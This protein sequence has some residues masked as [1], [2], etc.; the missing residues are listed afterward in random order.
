[1]TVCDMAMPIADDWYLKRDMGEGITLIIEPHVDVLM[2]ANIWHVR[3]RDRDLLVDS[4]M[5]IVPLRPYFPELF[6]GRETIALATHTHVDHI[7]AIHEFEHRWVHPVEAEALQ[8][9]GGGTLVC[10]EINPDAR[11]RFIAAG[12]PPLG[13]YLVHALPHAG[14]DPK[15]Y[16]LRGARPTRLIREGETVDLGDRQYT[17]LLVPGHSPGSIALFEE[18]TGTLFAGDVIYDGPLLYQGP[19]MDIGDYVRSFERL[20]S[21]PITTVHAGHDPSFSKTRL[22]AIIDAYM[23]RWRSEGLIGP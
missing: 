12:Y 15:S 20:R 9:P 8:H 16:V 19:A 23:A 11:R 21:L 14:Y 6:E 7:G 10:E 13:R 4:G 22:D 18:S 1:M 2:R 3:G 17:V 5:G